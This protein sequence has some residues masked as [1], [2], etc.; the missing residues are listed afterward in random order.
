MT[1]R[2]VLLLA[3][4]GLCVSISAHAAHSDRRFTFR[5]AE[6]LEADRGVEAAQ[7]YFRTALPPG[8]TMQ[9][10]RQR[11]RSADMRC[12]QPGSSD[13]AVVCDFHE[14]VHIE[15]GTLGEDHWT[16]RLLSDGADRL[17]SATLDRFTVGVGSP[18]L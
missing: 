9:E 10:A 16:V 7:E 13:A 6:F 17:A 4:W 8:I 18:G 2:P 12:R 15:G 11:L 14:T 5:D 1:S 3:V